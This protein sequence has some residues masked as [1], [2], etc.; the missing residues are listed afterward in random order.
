[1]FWLSPRY[2]SPELCRFIS[3]DNIE[4]VDPSSMDGLN[5]SCYFGNDPSGCFPLLVYFLGLL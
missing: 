1:M 4:Y 2:Y 5:L 3:L